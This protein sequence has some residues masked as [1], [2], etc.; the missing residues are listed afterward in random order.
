MVTFKEINQKKSCLTCVDAGVR[1][2]DFV[3][4][5]LNVVCYEAHFFSDLHTAVLNFKGYFE[6]SI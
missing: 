5:G 6:D 4:N 2:F 1:V 3:S